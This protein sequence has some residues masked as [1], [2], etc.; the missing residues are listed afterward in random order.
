MLRR[1]AVITDGGKLDKAAVKLAAS[2]GVQLVMA[3]TGDD[4]PPGICG[5]LA[6][7]EKFAASMKCV[8]AAAA[9][10]EELLYLLADS[11]DSREG[12]IPGSSRRVVE[13]ASRFAKAIGLSPEDQIT[14]ERAALLRDLGKISIPNDVLLKETLLSYEEWL[15]IQAHPH[16]GADV[17]EKT[18][19]L[20][21]VAEIIGTHHESFDGDG[22]PDGIEGTAIPLLARAL[23]ILDVYCAMTSPRLYRKGFSSQEDALEHLRSEQGKHFD[24]DLIETFLKAKVGQPW[25]KA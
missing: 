24:P 4:C 21:D 10:Q 15:L 14:L 20:K 12:L 11:L 7:V 3:G 2:E 19:A 8:L 18:Q 13:H 16:L 25:E 6:P 17:A 22:Y 23:K 9:Q 5:V 1:L